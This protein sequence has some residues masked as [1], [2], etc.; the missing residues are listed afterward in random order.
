MA[1]KPTQA[2]KELVTADV[3]NGPHGHIAYAAVTNQI[4]VL[5]SGT[6][7]VSLLD[8]TTGAAVARV[9]VG[10]TPVHMIIDEPTDRAY[11]LL[12]QDALAVVSLSAAAVRETI[13]L[14]AGSGPTCLV[15]LLG[16]QRL[17]VLNG[18]AGTVSTIDVA[19]LKVVKS[20]TVGARPSWGQPHKKSCGKIH[21]ANADSNTV[22][23]LDEVSG[24]VVATVP[25]GARPAR[26]AIFREANAMFT[27]N[28]DD[29]TL[30]GISLADDSVI[31]TVRVGRRPFRLLPVQKK[32][33]RPEVWTLCRGDG[34]DRGGIQVTNTQT[35]EVT[36]VPTVDR[37]ANWLFEGPIG[38]VVA[39]EAR[40]MQI[41]DTRSAQTI[42]E[43]A[44]SHDPDTGSL[45][46]MVFSKAGNLFLANAD[47]T[48]TAFAP[49]TT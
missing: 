5:N 40:Q 18:A 34:H 15:P 3:G 30:T 1:H 44:L 9:A 48:V 11:V 4:W 43:V 27:A 8:G 37:P 25:T 46:N 47:D 32:N 13:A 23:V 33:G 12:T 19:A 38:H 6:D 41:V 10:G 16:T 20:V 36:T 26:N 21:V 31:A 22:S 49:V 39:R 24:D 42:G 14:P 17:Y 2:F 35:G 7:T 45:S 28:R 29:G